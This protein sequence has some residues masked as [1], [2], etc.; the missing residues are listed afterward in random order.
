MVDAPS[1]FIQLTDQTDRTFVEAFAKGGYTGVCVCA[2][3]VLLG[4]GSKIDRTLRNLQKTQHFQKNYFLA[5]ILVRDIKYWSF[6]FLYAFGWLVVLD[7]ALVLC[8]CASDETQISAIPET[9]PP[10]RQPLKPELEQTGFL[11]WKGA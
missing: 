8:A 11:K 9:K 3:I 7:Y 2:E 1:I 10:L 5:V 4:T 6:L